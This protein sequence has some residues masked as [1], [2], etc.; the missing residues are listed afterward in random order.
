MT[1]S[2]P[3]V[4]VCAGAGGTG[5]EVSPE[6]Q[7]GHRDAL[8]GVWRMGIAISGS[9]NASKYLSLIKWV[10]LQKYHCM[11]KLGLLQGKDLCS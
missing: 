5:L 1:L 2:F 6:A 9:R 11:D 8:V 7:P 10:L 3:A 4:S